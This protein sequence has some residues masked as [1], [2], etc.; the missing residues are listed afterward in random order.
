VHH[1]IRDRV[2][3]ADAG[4]ALLRRDQTAQAPPW[5]HPG[6]IFYGPGVNAAAVLL[7]SYGNV[8]AERAATLTGMLLGGRVSAGFLDGA[9]KRL[10]GRRRRARSG[11]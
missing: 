1:G 7:T 4:L 2:P 9:S 11:G 5:E 8:P 10:P 6:G 3:A